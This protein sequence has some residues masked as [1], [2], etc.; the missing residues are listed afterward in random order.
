[1]KKIAAL[2]LAVLMLVAVSGCTVGPN[3]LSRSWDD[4]QNAWY[5][6][7]PWLYGNVVV[8]T[9]LSFVHMGAMWIDA[10]VNVYYFWGKDAQPFGSGRGTAFIHKN[11]PKPVMRK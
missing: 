7:S 2:S 6:K 11:P 10:I 5:Q 8:G 9:A 4:M 1:M 3:K